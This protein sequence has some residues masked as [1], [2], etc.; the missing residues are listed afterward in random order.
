MCDDVV[1]ESLTKYFILD[2]GYERPPPSVG[3]RLECHVEHPHGK[4][5]LVILVHQSN[6]PGKR[7]GQMFS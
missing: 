7:Q 5:L 6:L 2:D 1:A 3:F 4:D